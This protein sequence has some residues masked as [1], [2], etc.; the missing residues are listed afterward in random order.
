MALPSRCLSLGAPTTQRK[1]R[2]KY[3][4]LAAKGRVPIGMCVHRCGFLLQ[5]GFLP[6]TGDASLQSALVSYSESFSHLCL[7][8]PTRV[9]AS[10]AIARC[11]LG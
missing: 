2:N 4:Q 7:L 9:A 8:D 3:V 1:R 6:H 11:F 10:F 5:C